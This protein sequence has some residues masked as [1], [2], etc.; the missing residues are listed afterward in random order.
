MID[1]RL[2]MD[3]GGSLAQCLF[4]NKVD[5]PDDRSLFA[6][7]NDRVQVLAFFAFADDLKIAHINIFTDVGDRRRGLHAIILVDGADNVLAGAHDDLNIF[8]GDVL[9]VIDG[10]DVQRIR[11]SDGEGIFQ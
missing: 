1:H 11:D 5:H 2:D 10:K 3:I 9:K 6:F 8:T 7:I 4:D